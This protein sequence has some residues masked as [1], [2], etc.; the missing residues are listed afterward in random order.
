MTRLALTVALMPFEPATS[1]VS[2]L[3]SL[4]GSP[5]VQDFCSDV[6]LNWKR[7]VGGEAQA[8]AELSELAGVEADALARF[9]VRLVDSRHYELNGETLTARCFTRSRQLVCPECLREDVRTAGPYAPHCR[10][11]WQVAQLRHCPDHDVELTALPEADYPRHASD[12]AARV[13][14][15][16]A[17]LRAPAHG[18]CTRFETWLARRLGGCSDGTWL[19]RIDFDVVTCFCESLGVLMVHGAGMRRENLS[20]AQLSYAADQGFQACLSGAEGISNALSDIQKNSG[21]E[22][23]GYYTDFG[24]FA[25]W[26]THKRNCPRHAPLIDIVRNYI[27]SH[28]PIDK[29]EVV[30]GQPCPKRQLHSAPSASQEYGIMGG[31]IYAIQRAFAARA[32]IPSEHSNRFYFDVDKHSDFLRDIARGL[33][34]KKAGEY[35]GCPPCTFDKIAASDLITPTFKLDGFTE[36]YPREELQRLL[37]SC[38]H[39]PAGEGCDRSDYATIRD[40]IRMTKLSYIETI[41]LLQTGSA[42][43]I[44][45]V[46]GRAHFGSFLV[47]WRDLKALAGR[48]WPEGYSK[49]DLKRLLRVN[50]PTIAMLTREG[51]LLG[52]TVRCARNGLRMTTFSQRSFNRF[53]DSYVTLGCLAHQIGTQAKHVSSK[54]ERLGIDPMPFPARYSKIYPRAVIEDAYCECAENDRLKLLSVVSGR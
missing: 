51:I 48:D 3:A 14:D 23:P 32:G 42:R 52:E 21:S 40:S 18:K 34:R 30:L 7:L 49:R 41:R 16:L 31:R 5:Y 53:L 15:S 24:P 9:T 20:G 39:A 43:H 29:G 10:M 12:F 25:R 50:D 26:M 19:N 44:A 33:R 35:L 1:F 17:G 2:R 45:P 6:G 28:Y 22:R 8:L 38:L 27:W 4:N 46:R 13:R 54:L 47:N 36:S 11:R 37:D